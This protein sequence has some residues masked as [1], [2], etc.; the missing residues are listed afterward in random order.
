MRR[1]PP[2]GRGSKLYGRWPSSRSPAIGAGEVWYTHRS[3]MPAP[4]R[5]GAPIAFGAGPSQSTR[6]RPRSSVPVTTRRIGFTPS[7]MLAYL[8]LTRAGWGYVAAPV[9]RIALQDGEPRGAARHSRT[10][11]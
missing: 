2:S 11:A 6:E 1:W 8:L 10:S 7:A 3:V 4:G 9:G 5:T